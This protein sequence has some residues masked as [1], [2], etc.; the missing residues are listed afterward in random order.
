MK[1]AFVDVCGGAGVAVAV[2]RAVNSGRAAERAQGLPD[3][4]T[5]ELSPGKERYTVILSHGPSEKVG[6][7]C[8][9]EPSV[10]GTSW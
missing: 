4:R 10:E 7:R 8:A 6:V 9:M 2:W 5:S 1:N 3:R